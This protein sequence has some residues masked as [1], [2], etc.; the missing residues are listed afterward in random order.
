MRHWYFLMCEFT[1]TDSPESSPFI[2]G[3]GPNLKDATSAADRHRMFVLGLIETLPLALCICL[4]KLVEPPI[5][6]LA[7]IAIGLVGT[8]FLCWLLRHLTPATAIHVHHRD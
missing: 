1:R 5:P 2:E 4:G 7:S 3:R 8:V 6:Y